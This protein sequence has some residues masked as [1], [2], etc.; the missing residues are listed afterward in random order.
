[1]SKR[2][3]T[4][5]QD[6]S[7][8]P[9]DGEVLAEGETRR[10]ENPERNPDEHGHVILDQGGKAIQCK[11]AVFPSGGAG[12]T[13]HPGNRQTQAPSHQA[14]KMSLKWITCLNAKRKTPTPL[15]ETGDSLLGEAKKFSKLTPK[16]RSIKRNID[17]LNFIKIKDFCSVNDS[18]TSVKRQRRAWKKILAKRSANKELHPLE[19]IKKSWNATVTQKNPQNPCNQKTSE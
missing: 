19:Y 11:K 10:T 12:T 1:M 5:F 6:W 17:Q 16:A 18:V 9:Q 8:E 4:R 2:Q 3:S 13:G 14:E 7:H 15:E